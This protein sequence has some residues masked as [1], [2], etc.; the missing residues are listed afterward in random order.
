MNRRDFL[1]LAGMA[2]LTAAGG[3]RTMEQ[4]FEGGAGTVPWSG[5]NMAGFRVEPLPVVRVGVIGVGQR[6]PGHVKTLARIPGV[7]I[8]A[9]G[10]LYAN[11]T[12][13]AAKLVT[14]A[15]HPAPQE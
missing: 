3:C 5:C 4:I 12:A 6:G 8:V 11:R 7:Q 9:I 14:E 10:D 13:K 15:G 2:G 1:Q